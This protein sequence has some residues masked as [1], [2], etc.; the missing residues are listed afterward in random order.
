MKVATE[1]PARIITAQ[2][3]LHNAWNRVEAKSGM[4]G[5]D[6]ISVQRFSRAAS[7]FLRGLQTR[8]ASG[9]YRPLPLRL[10]ALEKKDGSRR[11]LL[12][13]SVSDRVALAAASQWL[14]GRWNAG[15][16]PASYAYRPGLGVSDAL[17]ALAELRDSG[18]TWVL[19]GDIRAFFDSIPHNLLLQRLEQSL[20]ADC[21]MLS[22]LRLW[23]AAPTW[24][25]AEVR[26][27][28]CGVP[29]GS[30]LS[31]LLANFYLDAFDR[32]LRAASVRFVRYA[33]DFLVLAR[34]P[35]ELAEHRQL[36][37][38]TL[39]SLRLQL[40]PDKTHMTR[41]EKV[42]RFLGA[43][44][45]T[46]AILLPVDKK[47]QPKKPAFVA[48]VMPPALLRAWRGGSLR[49]SGPLVWNANPA[50]TP[51][52]PQPSRARPTATHLL[53]LLRTIPL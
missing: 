46:D 12:V 29:Q 24:D 33:D 15:F 50:G 19:D 41:F 51:A 17:K 23:I 26:T 28:P 42:F 36:V 7:A 52:P 34:T 11:L 35:F 20:G 53:D 10:A 21:P 39:N 48:P 16:D 49:S 5:V 45:R 3:D 27:L 8:L 2:L 25:G 1:V 38:Q 4:C 13:P 32:I 47:K 37:E 44:L 43:E 18:Y 40:N 14:G 6:G 9:D 30:P 22:W 31:P